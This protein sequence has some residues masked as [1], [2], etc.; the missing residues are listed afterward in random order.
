[1]KKLILLMSMA[2]MLM[3][4]SPVVAPV[5]SQT[6]GGVTRDQMYGAMVFAVADFNV[7]LAVKEGCVVKF[8]ARRTLQSPMTTHWTLTCRETPEGMLVTVHAVEQTPTGLPYEYN[9]MSGA[10]QEYV[11]SITRM[12]WEVL[13]GNLP[14]IAAAK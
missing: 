1:M 9:R 5:A 2:A 4:K 7:S 3:A 8:N 11:G 6:F 13:K 14:V 12:F 10:D